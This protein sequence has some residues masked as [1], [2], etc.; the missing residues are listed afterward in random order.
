M[1]TNVVII[2]WENVAVSVSIYKNN[3]RKAVHN[4]KNLLFSVKGSSLIKCFVRNCLPQLMFAWCVGTITLDHAKTLNKIKI[5]V[6]TI[7]FFKLMLLL[8]TL[9]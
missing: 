7:H 4:V 8:F 1:K 2:F 6:L 9:I 3:F 5:Y